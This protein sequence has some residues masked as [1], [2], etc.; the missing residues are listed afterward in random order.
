MLVEKCNKLP[1]IKAYHNKCDFKFDPEV[2]QEKIQEKTK[3][4]EVK[5]KYATADEMEK[6]NRYLVRKMYNCPEGYEVKLKWNDYIIPQH[7]CV[8]CSE[9]SSLKK[10]VELK[11]PK[12]RYDDSKLEHVKCVA[13]P[14]SCPR[15]DDNLKP[16]WKRLP[17]IPTGKC[18]PCETGAVELTSGPLKMPIKRFD[19]SKMKEWR[20]VCEEPYRPPRMDEVLGLKVVRRRLPK[21]NMQ[22]HC[23]FCIPIPPGHK[24]CS[25]KRP[26]RRYN[27]NFEQKCIVKDI[28]NVSPPR[29]DDVLCWRPKKKH[30]PRLSDYK[31]Y[32]R[33]PTCLCPKKN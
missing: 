26:K 17:K 11:P 31:K 10:S 16:K 7:D 3:I 20:K 12:K 9:G 6:A 21:F 14:D 15:M 22:S 2:F 4:I 33:K 25:L 32:E 27:P 23:D 29:M 19:D 13:K 30:L 24:L 1:F 5:K 28:C 8:L 18:L